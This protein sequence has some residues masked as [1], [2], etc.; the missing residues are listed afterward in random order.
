M[1]LFI[2]KGVLNLNSMHSLTTSIDITKKEHDYRLRD[3][4]PEKFL[5]FTNVQKESDMLLYSASLKHTAENG[6][7]LTINQ[8]R[9]SSCDEQSSFPVR[10]GMTLFIFNEGFITADILQDHQSLQEYSILQP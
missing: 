9:D 4:I 1:V 2:E 3:N 6:D 7:L 8:Y 5:Y 10:A